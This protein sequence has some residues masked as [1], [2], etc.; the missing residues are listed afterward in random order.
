MD[1]RILDELDS[2]I[3]EMRDRYS[4]ISEE[5][6]DEGA[7]LEAGS[8]KTMK[9]DLADRDD[10]YVLTADLPGFDKDDISVRLDDGVL[11]V[12]AEHEESA[13]E[14][15]DD[16]I[17]RE[18]RR[19]SVRR[20]VRLPA[21]VEE[22]EVSAKFNNGVLTVEVPKVEAESEKGKTIEIE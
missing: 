4:K 21:L 14:E 17:T 7:P 6:A 10:E 2:M 20:S 19:R 13:E 11:T 22:E 15:E 12:S 1:R 8:T 9:I 18:R 5:P 3:D 16:Y